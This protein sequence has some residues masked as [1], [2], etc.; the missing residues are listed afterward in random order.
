M[1]TTELTFARD[2]K[3][4]NADAPLFPTNIYTATLV[5]G[6]ATSITIP[7]NYPNFIMYVRVQPDGW[8]WCSATATAA[9][10]AGG[11]LTDATSELIVG[12][13]EFRR[14]VIKGQVISFITSNTTCD[15]E[16]SLQALK[17]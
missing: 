17:T 9:V 2:T 8:C 3:G 14:T 6:T 10:P 4:L 13:V 16:V 7:A 5:N 1:A 11:T 12:T 15:I